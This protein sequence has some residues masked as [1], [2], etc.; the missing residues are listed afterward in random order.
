MQ[1]YTASCGGEKLKKVVELEMGILISPGRGCKDIKNSGVKI[2]IDNGA[3]GSWTRGFPFM[4]DVFRSHLADAYKNGVNAQFIVCPDIVAGGLDSLA[5]SMSWALGEL[6]G[7]RLALAVQDGMKPSNIDQAMLKNF[8]YI[9]VG[10]SIK[11]KWSTLPEWVKY[12]KENNKK[13]HVGRVGSLNKLEY[14]EKLGVDSVDS[15]NYARHDSWDVIETFLENPQS[16][17]IT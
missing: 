6:L 10:G 16:K 1:V 5:F 17:L 3:Y 13:I 7:A 4:A 15:S 8:I 14:C 11:W 2:A 9:F 12:A